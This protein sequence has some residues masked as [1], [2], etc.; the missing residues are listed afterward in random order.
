M[1]AVKGIQFLIDES[2][3]AS[4]VLLDLKRHRRIWEDMDDRMLTESRQD[5]P[6]ETLDEV[7]KRLERKWKRVRG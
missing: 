7:A 3:V 5:E 1:P 6:R 2:G 4:G